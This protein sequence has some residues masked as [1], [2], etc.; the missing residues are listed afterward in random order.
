MRK[1]IAIVLFSLITLSAAK[2][3]VNISGH[4]RSADSIPIANATILLHDISS[5]QKSLVSFTA[6]D[7]DGFYSFKVENPRSSYLLTARAESFHPVER[8]INITG[9]SLMLEENFT[10][11]SSVS[12]LDTVKVD[13]R[14]TISKTGD[15]ISFNP[16]A[17]AMDNETTIEHLLT[18]L[19]GMEIKS[20]GS[21]Y[22]NGKVVSAVLIDGDDLFK[23]N[24]QLLTQNAAPKIIEQVQV[25]KNHQS[26]P[27][28]KQ[29]NRQGE[30]VINLKI[31]EQ[32]KNYLFGHAA[33][34]AGNKDNRLAD[35]FLIRLSPQAKVQ[36]GGNY[37]TGG[38]VY[39]SSD[40]LSAADMIRNDNVFS[41]YT[42]AS[43]ILNISRY[44]F[45]NL[46]GY[47]QNRNES[48]QAYTN[49]LAKKNKWEN[50]LNARY[51]MDRLKNDQI[52]RA[53]YNDGTV[54]FTHNNGTLRNYLYDFNYTGSLKTKTESIYI[55]AALQN[56][57]RRHGSE[58]SSNQSLESRQN[59]S[60]NNLMWQVNL[61]Y[62]RKISETILWSNT[63]GYFKQDA[64]Q[65]L[66]TDPDFLFW[67]FPDDLSL[68]L[69]ES[70]VS[71]QLQY[72]KFKS[73]LLIR[74]KRLSSE[75]GVSYTNEDRLFKSDLHTK[76][77]A[78]GTIEVPFQN[79]SSLQAPSWVFQYKGN[80]RLSAKTRLTLSFSGEPHFYKH[81]LPA[82]FTNDTRF[83]YDYSASIHSKR[84]ISD[85]SL[86]LGATKRPV[87][88]NQFF[89]EFVQT[90][91]HRLQSG[92][93]DTRGTSSSYLQ[94]RYNITSVQ[95]GWVGSAFL[96]FSRDETDF[97]RKLETT[98]IGTRSSF[99][100]YP[101]TTNH[102][103]F[104]LN[105]QKTM[106]DWPFSLDANVMYGVESG[107]DAFQN[108]I[109][110]STLRFFNGSLGIKSHFKSIFNFDHNFSLLSSRNRIQ[111]PVSRQISTHTY[112]NTVNMH[113]VNKKLVNATLRFNSMIT[114]NGAFNGNFLD[115]DLN[116]KLA[117]ERLLL[118]LAVRNIFNQKFLL[119]THLSELY[120]QE[121][122]V[123]IRGAEFIVSARYEFR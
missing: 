60:G 111:V 106:G 21:I 86:T 107:F 71:I 31:K 102:L 100:Y 117:K 27:L 47:Y 93:T 116:R 53:T 95:F 121:N 40:R 57:N 74:G 23:R 123:E 61:A 113:M 70:D 38:T 43:D 82:T 45:Y 36:A 15:T 66:R 42:P 72:L 9:T 18:R 19:P 115:V 33:A 122:R 30:Q 101:N 90:G 12:F 69:L 11:H 35:L 8:M 79:N 94:S 14:M 84:R 25:F 75:L 78:H 48:V 65:D 77:I 73:G 3:Q 85:L 6:A 108:Q 81:R 118:G 110:K 67:A 119:N 88:R 24:Y 83:F 87:G 32:Y 80:L 37:N 58:T 76:T 26:D 114:N 91:F 46:P 92:L 28:L 62:N 109:N 105:S 52:H 50:T 98:G 63:I 17:F 49:A 10:L 29:F 97:I 39:T 103:M 20:D 5:E 22:F 59:L 41:S 104:V 68:Y 96:R 99:L 112:L 4:I 55:N 2:G 120:K 1:L 13:V 34:G 89:P 51:G 16:K 56:R 54:L 7:A 44:Y 64:R